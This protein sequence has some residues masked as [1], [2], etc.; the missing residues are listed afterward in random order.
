M[1]RL[2]G[3]GRALPSAPRGGPGRRGRALVS[4]G[5]A[6]VSCLPRL[7]ADAAA[8][9]CRLC[10]VSCVWMGLRLQVVS[11]CSEAQ[12]RPNWKDMSG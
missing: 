6:A 12:G 4:D 11:C 10:P 5:R 8:G 7:G 9:L 2:P 1:A 3:G